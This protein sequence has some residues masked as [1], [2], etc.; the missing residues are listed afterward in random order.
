MQKMFMSSSNLR[1]VQPC[2]FACPAKKLNLAFKHA[3]FGLSPTA[4]WTLLGA[5]FTPQHLTCL[6]CITH[7]WFAPRVLN[8]SAR[9]SLV[10]HPDQHVMA[11]SAKWVRARA[12]NQCFLTR[13][14]FFT[15]TSMS[16]LSLP[17][18]SA[19][20]PQINDLQRCFRRTRARARTPCQMFKRNQTLNGVSLQQLC[21]NRLSS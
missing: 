2:L 1:T 9:L 16:W 7:V 5:Q 17:N 18:G 4:G 19:R 10:F 15:P 20:A 12:P 11:I 8:M 13:V 3:R 14:W 21:N 6:H